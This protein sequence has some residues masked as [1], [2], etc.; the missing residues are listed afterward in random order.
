MD[1]KEFERTPLIYLWSKEWPTV[2]TVYKCPPVYTSPVSAK[3]HSQVPQRP[4]PGKM[5]LADALSSDS[6][7]GQLNTQQ[8][9]GQPN[10]PT[11][12]GQPNQPT[13][14]GQPNQ[15]TWPGQPNQ[16][17]WPGQPNQ[18]TWPGQPTGPAPYSGPPLTVPYDLTLPNGCYDKMLISIKGQFQ[19]NAKMMTINFCRNNDIA[20]HFNPRF[21]DHGKPTIVRNSMVGDRWGKE[22]RELSHFPFTQGSPFQV[23]I[24][25]TRTE[26]K[27]AVNDQHLLEFKHRIHELNQV[28]HLGIYNDI[29]LTSVNVETLP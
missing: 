9:P 26:F 25:C 14:P 17:T 8:W 2:R 18:P 1:P 12:P 21:N 5:D 20:M 3:I 13:W 10:Q 4:Q 6:N 22:E 19:A 28:S 27:I 7:A 16:P 29:T 11:W 24:L 23:K 15:P